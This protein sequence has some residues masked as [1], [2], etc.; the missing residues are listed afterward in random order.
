VRNPRVEH[1]RDEDRG[2]AETEAIESVFVGVVVGRHGFRRHDMVEEAAMLVVQD[3]QQ[4]AFEQGLVGSQ[5]VV[6]LW[7]SVRRRA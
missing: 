6:D 3:D 5:R 2:D 7:R 4:G 1:R